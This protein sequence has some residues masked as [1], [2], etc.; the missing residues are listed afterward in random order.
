M[1]ISNGLLYLV[2]TPIGNLQD[3]TLRALETLSV[4]DLVA[5]ENVRHTRT[6]L[7][8]HGISTRL[9][10][11]REENSHKRIPEILHALR[12]GAKVALV[13]DAGMP[14]ISDPGTRLVEAVVAEYHRVE[15]VPGPSAVLAALCAS[16]LSA[17]PFFFQGF[18]PRSRSRRTRCLRRLACLDSTLVFYE[19]PHRILDSVSD[20]LEELGDRKCVVAR[21]I[22]KVHEEYLRGTLGEVLNLIQ[23]P[24]GE[25]TVVVAGCA[26][27]NDKGNAEDVVAQVSDLVAGGMSCSDAVRRVSATTGTSRREVYRLAHSKETV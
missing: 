22:T 18:L 19:A 14:G 15:V 6:L 25:F 23:E 27:A 10:S 20:M 11:F 21:E 5:A 26:S 12:E 9:T 24:K 7:K 17:S 3:I 4:V 13:S 8:Y 2:G 16:G 1:A